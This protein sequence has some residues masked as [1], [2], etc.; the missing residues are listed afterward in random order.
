[1]GLLKIISNNY[2]K[3]LLCLVVNNQIVWK[4]VILAVNT[5]PIYNKGIDKWRQNQKHLNPPKQ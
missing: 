1:M 4:D 5:Q 3:Y 2:G